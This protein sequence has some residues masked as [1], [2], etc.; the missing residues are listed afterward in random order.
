MKKNDNPIRTRMN[1]LIDLSKD[2]DEDGGWR[3]KG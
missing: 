2:E 3:K 1:L